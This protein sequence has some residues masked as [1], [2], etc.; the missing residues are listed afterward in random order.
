MARNTGTF[1]FPSNFEVKKAAPLDARTQTGLKSEL[2]GLPFMYKGMVVSVTEDTAENNGV[3][4]LKTGDG[5]SASDWEL[6]SGSTIESMS[7]NGTD[8]VIT[9][10]DGTSYTSEILTTTIQAPVPSG[11]VGAA[12]ATA[13]IGGASGTISFV[14]GSEQTNG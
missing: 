14:S 2:T 9:M 12:S 3:Y 10:T 13:V 11:S 7:Y 4:T 8:L 6:V 5:A 1:E